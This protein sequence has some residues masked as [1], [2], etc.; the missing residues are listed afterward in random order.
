VNEE[1]KQQVFQMSDGRSSPEI[2][3]LAKIDPSTV[4]DYWKEWASVGL[5]EIHPDF[6]KRYHRVFSLEDVGIEP[7]ETVTGQPTEQESQERPS[8]ESSGLEKFTKAAEEGNP[9]DG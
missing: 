9:Q 1:K 8:Q 6:K 3:K 5:M 2:A 4:R 7:P